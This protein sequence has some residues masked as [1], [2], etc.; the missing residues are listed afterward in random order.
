MALTTGRWPE[1]TKASQ[2][3]TLPAANINALSANN[4]GRAF[5]AIFNA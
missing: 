3:R 5:H 4:R 1:G 2:D